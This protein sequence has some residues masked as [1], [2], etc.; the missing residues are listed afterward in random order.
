[1]KTYIVV[2]GP[3]DA[4]I[5]RATLSPHTVDNTRFVVGGGQSSG[6]SLARS[7]I[8]DRGEPLLLVMD[9]DTVHQEAIL[10]QEKAYRELLGAVAINTPYD[11]VLAIPELEVIFFQDLDVLAAIL[12]MPINKEV[13]VN[14]LY[15]PRKTLSMLL[16][17]SPQHIHDTSQ[18]LQ[19]IDE[20]ARKKMA[21]HSI[22]RKIEDF[23]TN[24]AE[25]PTV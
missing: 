15:E 1:M 17:K 24:A 8:S 10:E 6:V 7:L 19:L 4:E 9:A 20:Q 25:I 3:F 11:V 13:A 14:S 2:E 18:L 16:K 5:L 12:R 22:I 21:Q 23:I